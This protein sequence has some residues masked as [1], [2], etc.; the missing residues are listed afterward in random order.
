MPKSVYKKESSGSFTKIA[1]FYTEDELN[2][3]LE[4]YLS[5]NVATDD[6]IKQLLGISQKGVKMEV[7]D[8]LVKASSLQEVIN[9]SELYFNDPGRKGTATIVGNYGFGKGAQEKIILRTIDLY[10]ASIQMF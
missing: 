8:K 10:K 6:E 9:S 2:S 4:T 3:Y 5:Q 1:T 7:K